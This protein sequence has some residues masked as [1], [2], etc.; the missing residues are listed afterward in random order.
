MD[1]R[2]LKFNFEDLPEGWK[3]TNLGKFC[4][5]YNGKAHEICIDEIGE[6]IVEISEF[7]PFVQINLI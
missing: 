5:F 6:V 1:R 7:V 4:E 3:V 2:Q